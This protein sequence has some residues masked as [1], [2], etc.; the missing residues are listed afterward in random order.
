M[1][2]Q[3]IVRNS[4]L[5]EEVGWAFGLGL[6]RL[7]MVL[8]DI[9]D[10]RLFWSKDPRFLSQFQHGEITRFKPYSKYPACYKDV[11]F[12]HADFHEN[13]LCEVVRDVAGD[14]VEQVV[15][16]DAFQH[17]KTKRES[18]CYRILYRHM[19]RNL[20]NE[21]VDKLQVSHIND[22]FVYPCL[23]AMCVGSS[24]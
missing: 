23:M 7:A 5:G 16:V 19:D 1:L 4:G 10:I 6:E 20:T 13:N 15:L 9:P 21:E 2:Q 18:K 14:M 11:S 22:W 8:F 24:A 3:Q 17:P 12:W